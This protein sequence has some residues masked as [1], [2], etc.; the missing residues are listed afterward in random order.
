MSLFSK[1]EKVDLHPEFS[2]TFSA[3]D[4]VLFDDNNKLVKTNFSQFSSKPKDYVKYEDILDINIVNDN[5]IIKKSGAG[6]AATGALLF[7]PVGLVAGGLTRGKKKKEVT[8]K[9]HINLILKNGTVKTIYFINSKT[10]HNSIVYKAIYPEF[11]SAGSKFEEVINNN[12][13]K[14]D[15]KQ[16]LID[17]KELLDLNVISQEDF[18]KRKL[19]ILRR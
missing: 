5:D 15:I 19:E 18:D 6:A 3:G 13:S 10:K 16:E 17:L 14:N 2:P 8:E 7:G 9:L 1:K 12:D 4:L 11:L